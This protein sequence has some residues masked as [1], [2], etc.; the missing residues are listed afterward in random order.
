VTR[1]YER[2]AGGGGEVRGD[3][4]DDHWRVRVWGRFQSVNNN[5]SEKELGCVEC[6]SLFWTLL[7]ISVYSHNSPQRWEI[8]YPC[9]TDKFAT[10]S[11]TYLR[12]QTPHAGSLASG[13]PCL[14]QGHSLPGCRDGTPG[15]TSTPWISLCS[16]KSFRDGGPWLHAYPLEPESKRKHGGQTDKQECQWERNMFHS[17]WEEKGR[18]LS[19]A[20]HRE[21]SL[22][23]SV[24]GGPILFSC[25]QKNQGDTS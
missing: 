22:T 18:C 1:K 6:S 10:A 7:R 21:L 15:M 20:M 8:Q 23:D 25:C 19:A 24:P 17:A 2:R 13:C 4:Q 12:S 3:N 16:T 11:G 9:S 5:I 14:L